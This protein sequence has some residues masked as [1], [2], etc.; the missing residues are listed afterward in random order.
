[1][2]HGVIRESGTLT[3]GET[4]SENDL[5]AAAEFRMK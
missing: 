4:A 3:R 1:M 5:V 2:V